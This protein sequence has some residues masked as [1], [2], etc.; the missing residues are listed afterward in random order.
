MNTS[1]KEYRAML[2]AQGVEPATDRIAFETMTAEQYRQLMGVSGGQNSK[3]KQKPKKPQNTTPTESVEQQC[4]MR[5]AEWARGKYPELKLLYHIPNEG[6]RSIATGGKLR[7][8]GLRKGVPD[9]CLPVPRGRYHGLYI[10][11][12]RLKGGRTS[13]EQKQW[14]SDL[15]AVGH[16]AV[17]CNGWVAAKTEIENYLRLPKWEV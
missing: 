14:L 3:Q 1:I 6:K 8:E 16:R 5:W 11:L 9:I 13:P 17:V 10:E 12:K 2:L 4:L 7:A 15:Q